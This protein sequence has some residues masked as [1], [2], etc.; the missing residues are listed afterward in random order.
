MN[1]S[2]FSF[3]PSTSL[4]SI[5]LISTNSR[6]FMS[7][8]SKN[9][10][11]KLRIFFLNRSFRLWIS[12][13]LEETGNELMRCISLLFLLLIFKC[14]LL[15]DKWQCLIWIKYAT[16]RIFL[17]ATTWFLICKFHFNNGNMVLSFLY[18]LCKFF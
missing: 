6:V 17:L 3:F 10:K 2:F 14:M 1:S 9:V 16:W 18:N 13:Y 8:L 12:Y 7:V 5:L 15:Y 4:S 11:I